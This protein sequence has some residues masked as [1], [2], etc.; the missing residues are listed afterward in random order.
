MIRFPT[1]AE[2]RGYHECIYCG[3]TDNLPLTIDHAWKRGSEPDK[4]LKRGNLLP[5]CANCNTRKADMPLKLWLLKCGD[6]RAIHLRAM[7]WHEYVSAQGALGPVWFIAMLVEIVGAPL[8]IPSRIE[9]TALKFEPYEVAQ[10]KRDPMAIKPSTG[11]G[12]HRE[13]NCRCFACSQTLA[14]SHDLSQCPE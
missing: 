12:F 1:N 11:W 2:I 3:A 14:Q 13:T 5:A 4:K 8:S 10:A 7:R 6:L 9:L